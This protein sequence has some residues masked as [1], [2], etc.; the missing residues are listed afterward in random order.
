MGVKSLIRMK[1]RDQ[2]ARLGWQTVDQ[3]GFKQDKGRT[4]ITPH[5]RELQPKLP[6]PHELTLP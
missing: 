4:G 6:Q 5:G 1:G 2:F 3:R